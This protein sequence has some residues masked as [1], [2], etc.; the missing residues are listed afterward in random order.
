MVTHYQFQPLA[1]VIV[2]LY[3]F[4]LGLYPFVLLKTFR[5]DKTYNE[6]EMVQYEDIYIRPELVLQSKCTNLLVAQ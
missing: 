6:V 3:E 5:F 2:H 1:G 4:K